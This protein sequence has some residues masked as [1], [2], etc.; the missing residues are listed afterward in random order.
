MVLKN[1]TIKKQ[2]RKI[3]LASFYWMRVLKVISLTVM[4]CCL[5]FGFVYL[6]RY[7]KQAVPVAQRT[8][9][10]ELVSPPWWL[11][12]ALKEKI[13]AA[14]TENGENLKLDEDAAESVRQNLEKAGGWLDNVKVQTTGQTFR[15][16]AKWR[17]PLAVI[18]TAKETF[19]VDADS[20]VMDY[21]E[22]QGLPVIKIEGV[23]ESADSL[24][25]GKICRIDAPAAC[26]RKQT[27]GDDIAAAVAVLER[28]DKRDSLELQ[29]HGLLGQIDRIDVSNFNGRK[30]EKNPHIVLYAADDTEIIW[31]AEVGK[32]YR[33]LEVTDEQKIARLYSFFNE[34]GTLLGRAKT[35]NLRD[36]K[37]SVPL[38]IDK[39]L[40]REN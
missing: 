30:S 10:L 26:L 21:V 17:R 2:K 19:Y 36:P 29:G 40:A 20:C 24:Q 14:A 16:W 4:P 12:D 35:I 32:W 3:D 8:G 31:G 25:T 1:N 11:N 23:K 13:Y 34:K 33:H 37:E 28:L 27:A 38:P 15:I 7:V 22:V 6:D 18:K 9:A 5:F 39:Y